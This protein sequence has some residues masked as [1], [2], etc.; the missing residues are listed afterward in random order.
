MV[1]TI[2]L[3]GAPVILDVD[4]QQQIV[5]GHQAWSLLARLLLSTRPLS[6]R[7]LAAELFPDTVDPLGSLRWTLAS[8]RKSLRCAEA[9]RSDSIVTQL[10][11]GTL[12]DVLRLAD[13]DFDVQ[14]VG[15]LLEGV[16]PQCGPEFSTWLLFERERVAGLTD[17]RLRQEAQQAIAVGDPERAVRFAELC[18]S[19]APFDEGVH[20]L[21]VKT[22]VAAGRFDAAAAHVDATHK[23]FMVALGQAPSAALRS[24]A[25]RTLSSPP[26]GVSPRAVVES[27]LEAGLAALSAGAVD[28]GADCLRRAATGAEHCADHQLQTKTLVELGTALVHSVRGHDDEGAILLRQSIEWAQRCR[29]TRL[30]SAAYRELDYVDALAGRRPTASAHLAQALKIAEDGDELAGI[31]SVIGFNLVDW[32]RVDEGLTHYRTS[33]E[34]AY[35][36]GNRRRQVWSLGIGSR[37]LLAA[38]RL[39][40]AESWLTDC[41]KG[42]DELRW[43][44]F[45]PWPCA[46]FGE[47]RLRQDDKPLA[48]QHD[49]EQAFALSCQLA[50]P[51]G[52][53]SWRAPWV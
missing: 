52:K 34:H 33:L 53:P 3:M 7:M 10:P 18:V 45:R 28:A 43:A 6:R 51:A 17:A 5:R 27:L 14:D 16:E 13:A 8:L 19:R 1:M 32:G 11:E 31:H 30:A 15:P 29:D 12:V 26:S 4:G 48:L 36:T 2:R 42:V 20:I 22:L 49:L 35:R 40:E 37:G 9:L 39:A 44:S 50:D 23:L 38:D 47:S 41:L 25:R 46:L 24:A 21:L